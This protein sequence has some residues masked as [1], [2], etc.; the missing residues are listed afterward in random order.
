MSGYLWAGVKG[1]SMPAWHD[2]PV[3]DLRALAAYVGS[4]EEQSGGP[5]L[6]LT[7]AETDHARGLFL[8]NCLNCHGVESGGSGSSASTLAPAA[9]SFRQVRP[10]IRYAEEVLAAGVPGTSMTSWKDKLPDSDRRLLARYVRTL[11]IEE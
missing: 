6:H 7:D 10:T 9:A 1:S 5:G 11:F 2:M 4:L 8:K 3:N